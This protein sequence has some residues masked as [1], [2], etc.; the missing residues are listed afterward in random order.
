[1]SPAAC[2]FYANNCSTFN[3]QDCPSDN[4]GGNAGQCVAPN[5]DYQKNGGCI[6]YIGTGG[7]VIYSYECQGASDY[8]NG[9]Q[10][11]RV[12]HQVN[13]GQSICLDTK[14]AGWCGALQ[15]DGGSG[16]SCFVSRINTTN[17]GGGT[18]TPAP[19]VPPIV[20]AQ[21]QNIKAYNSSWTVLT[22]AQL[23]ALAPATVVNFCV[24]GSATTGV[25]DKAQFTINSVAQAETTTQ[26]PGS[27][28]FCQNYTIPAATTTFA[29]T[30]QIHH[31][32]LG[33]K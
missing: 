3:L 29:V 19:T 7:G 11:N 13:A 25:F 21:C 15:I 9:C 14:P 32:T 20:T 16:A 17:C 1:L 10:Q 2:T 6:K 30:A 27:Q 28:D 22:S 4:P 26:R 33:W 8:S 18:P 5:V 31:V 12:V 23:S 24:V